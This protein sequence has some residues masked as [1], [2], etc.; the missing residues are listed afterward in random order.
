[1]LKLLLLL[2]FQSQCYLENFGVFCEAS[3]KVVRGFHILKKC[4][5]T[6][7]CLKFW[8]VL[9]GEGYRETVELA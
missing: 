9:P 6:D 2:C 5:L 8:F 3:E 7:I 4:R 1:M